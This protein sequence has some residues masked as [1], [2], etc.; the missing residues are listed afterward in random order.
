M[1]NDLDRFF[2]QR[3]KALKFDSVGTSF[4]LHVSEPVVMEQQ[5]DFD[6]GEPLFWPS[7]DKKMQAL[8]TGTVKKGLQGPD[9]DGRRTLY[10]KG[11]MQNAVSAAMRAIGGG[12]PEPGG[13]LTITFVRTGEKKGRGQAPKLYTASYVPATA[14]ASE[15]FFSDSKSTQHEEVPA[16]TRGRRAKATVPAT[17]DAEEDAPF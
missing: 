1:S 17:A 7:G 16:Q 2:A 13:V 11:Y 5:T 10:V 3:A 15:E 9:D 6:S 8:I 14:A 12:V 4:E